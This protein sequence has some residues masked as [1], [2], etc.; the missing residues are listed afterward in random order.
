MLRF[1]K[2]GNSA[3]QDVNGIYSHVVD[4]NERRRLALAEVD[5]APLSWYH[6]RMVV[7]TGLG[8]WTDSYTVCKFTLKRL[9]LP[10]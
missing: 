10:R 7:V 6:L 2:S 1:S 9:P 3:Y 4:P 8:F 5:K